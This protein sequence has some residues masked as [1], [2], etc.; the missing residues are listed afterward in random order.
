MELSFII[1]INSNP[2]GQYLKAQIFS[3]G[4]KNELYYLW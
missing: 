2:E 3:A 4:N 1:S